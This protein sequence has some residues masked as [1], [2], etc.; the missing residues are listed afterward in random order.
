MRGSG[1]RVVFDEV[2]EERGEQT[3]VRAV[4]VVAGDPN[5]V[6]LSLSEK[7]DLLSGRLPRASRSQTALTFTQRSEPAGAGVAVAWG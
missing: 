6:E 4:R 1:G 7:S 5:S 3:A 2:R